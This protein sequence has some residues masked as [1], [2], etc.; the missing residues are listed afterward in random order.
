MWSFLL[1]FRLDFT[2]KNAKFLIN[3]YKTIDNIS[4]QTFITIIQLTWFFLMTTDIWI[5]DHFNLRLPFCDV[6]NNHIK[7]KVLIN[8]ILMM[9]NKVIDIFHLLTAT[10]VE[11]E[12][13]LI[14]NVNSYLHPQA[15]VD[16]FE[17]ILCLYVTFSTLMMLILTKVHVVY[18]LYFW[19]EF[20]IAYQEEANQK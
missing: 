8:L 12:A 16:A 4:L 6:L 7:L 9:L 18:N 19:M 1:Q 5:V 20:W 17:H 14:Q 10:K 15:W 2:L 13:I 11:D 3:L